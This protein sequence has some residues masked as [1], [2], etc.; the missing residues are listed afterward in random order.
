MNISCEEVA[1]V[2]NIPGLIL[3]VSC[4]AAT[5]CGN[6]EPGRPQFLLDENAPLM[7]RVHQEK[8]SVCLR[9][10]ERGSPQYANL[11]RWTQTALTAWI[12]VLAPAV[13]QDRRASLVRNFEFSAARNPNSPC[14]G[15]DG[16]TVP[17]GSID[18]IVSYVPTFTRSF[19][20][21]EG[22]DVWVN[23]AS[24]Y[25]YG[26][27]LH[28]LGHA[29]GLDDTYLERTGACQQDQPESLMCHSQNGRLLEDDV[30]G[31]QAAYRHWQL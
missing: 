7:P 18:L 22:K 25:N 3:M 14:I 19:T 21:V 31:I 17:R 28:E 20:Y 16:A 30:L 11:E 13:P 23:L 4:V 27:L 1:N 24:N 15:A 5:G 6:P 9:G 12:D 8:L 26:T 2:R 29:W 10:Y